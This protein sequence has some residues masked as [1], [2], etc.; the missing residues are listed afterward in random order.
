MATQWT[1][2]PSMMGGPGSGTQKIAPTVK[3]PLFTNSITADLAARQKAQRLANQSAIN[4]NINRPASTGVPAQGATAVGN[5]A[6]GIANRQVAPAL[7]SVAG[8]VAGAGQTAQNISNG[9]I[10]KMAA[11][12]GYQVERDNALFKQASGVASDQM[13]GNLPKG[14]GAGETSALDLL[15]QQQAQRTRATQES[16]ASAGIANTGKAIQ[17]GIINTGAQNDRE[18]MGMQRD[19]LAART[20][21]QQAQI[22]QGQ[23]AAQNLA[24][25]AQQ[26]QQ[27]NS[28]QIITGAG[29]AGDLGLR[30][31]TQR[32]DATQTDNSNAT[33]AWKTNNEY[34]Q[35]DATRG[36]SKTEREA[37][38]VY[39][40]GER[41]AAQSFSASES[42]KGRALTKLGMSSDMLDSIQNLVDSGSIDAQT[43]SD[44]MGNML[45]GM[46][47]GTGGAQVYNPT[48]AAANRATQKI[49]DDAAAEAQAD[50]AEASKIL[51]ARVASVN[52]QGYGLNEDGHI[53]GYK[54]PETGLWE[55]LPVQPLTHT[56]A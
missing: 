49:A 8:Q 11:G 22:A 13:T 41:E 23:A 5:V 19:Q 48:T 47:A 6:A 12:G 34:N 54:N 17:E 38:Q 3:K 9:Q 44:M 26:G 7:S 31:G 25:M 4:S 32:A 28:Q 20:T 27:T 33:D 36:F 24:T 10:A 55:T 40:T 52:G 42:E 16:L 37:G 51:G 2:A 43:A 18:V 39:N 35:A 29:V 1:S 15:K 14:Y 56:A 53:I 46:S 50:A 21:A 30:A 45:N